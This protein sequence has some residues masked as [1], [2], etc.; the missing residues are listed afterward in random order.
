MEF[1]ILETDEE[2]SSP[3]WNK[4]YTTNIDSIEDGNPSEEGDL[5]VFTDG[6]K[7]KENHTG[8]GAIIFDMQAND[9][10]LETS[11]YLGKM[12]TVFQ[13]EVYAIN[14][15]TKYLLDKNCTNK[16]IIIHTESFSSL[17]AL[18]GIEINLK[19][20]KLTIENLNKLATQN[21]V[22]IRWV[23]AHVGHPGNEIADELAKKGTEDIENVALD[24]PNISKS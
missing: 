10:M 2:A 11:Q 18:A 4:K 20:I 1:D 15:V 21:Q 17:Q 22:E 16:T 13:S 12:L 5:I 19:Q 23:K 24:L 6:S 14:M 8:A 3:N 7:Y 9:R